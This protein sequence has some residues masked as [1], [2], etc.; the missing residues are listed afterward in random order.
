M[1]L[2]A[3]GNLILVL[4]TLWTLLW[5]CYSVWIAAKNGDKKWFAALVI[6]NTV[7]ILDMI[8]VFKIAKKTWPEVKATFLKVISFK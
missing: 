6:F 7:G 2:H 4:I 8:Y 3:T 5:K 1:P